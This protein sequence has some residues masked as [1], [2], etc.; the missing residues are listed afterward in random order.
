MYGMQVITASRSERIV[1][2]TGLRPVQF[3]RLVATVAERGGPVI[4]DGCRD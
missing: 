4:A 1:P 2:V 3:R